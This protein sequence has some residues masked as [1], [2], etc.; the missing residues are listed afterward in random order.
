MITKRIKE[1]RGFLNTNLMNLTEKHEEIENTNVVLAHTPFT[2][3]LDVKNTKFVANEHFVGSFLM[4]MRKENTQIEKD[5]STEIKITTENISLKKRYDILKLK[6]ALDLNDA[7]FMHSK[8]LFLHDLTSTEPIFMKKEF[9]SFRPDNKFKIKSVPRCVSFENVD[10]NQKE[11]LLLKKYGEKLSEQIQ[12]V[13]AFVNKISHKDMGK[14]Y[15]EILRKLCVYSFDPVY[16][17][18]MEISII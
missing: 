3:L 4:T 18:R 2:T 13:T 16:A 14:E 1:D 8:Q 15:F 7:I 17:Q 6:N 9:K 5:K 12:I 11:E 10:V